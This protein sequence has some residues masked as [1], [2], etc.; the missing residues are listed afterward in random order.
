[1][2]LAPFLPFTS[3]KLH[4]FLG[5]DGQLF[6]DLHIVHCQET[7][8]THQAL[9]Y[10]GSWA[11]GRWEKSALTPGQALREPAPLI[12]KLEPEVVALERARLGQPREEKPITM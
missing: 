6:G 11:I 2:L 1:V 12:V 8:K 3:Q 5:Y 4:E 10:D 9:V 7:E